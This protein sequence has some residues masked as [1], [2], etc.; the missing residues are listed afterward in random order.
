VQVVGRAKVS[1]V[2]ECGSIPGLA[3]FGCTSIEV[4]CAEVA[5]LCEHSSFTAVGAGTHDDM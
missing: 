1:G 3:I 4:D 2:E 5:C